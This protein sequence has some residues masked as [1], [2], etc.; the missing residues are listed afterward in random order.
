MFKLLPKN[1]LSDW[2]L[3][4]N[5]LSQSTLSDA[6]RKTQELWQSCPFTPF[7]LDPEKSQD[8]PDPWQLITEN[9]YC[10][11]ARCLG[12]I[13]TLHLTAH[14]DQLFPELRTYVDTNTRYDYHIAYLCHGKYVLNLIEGE[15]VNKEHINQQLKLKR[16]YTTADLKL[17]QY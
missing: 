11:L 16:C 7:Y 15:V 9:Y 17:E 2:K 8:W 1:R 13:Y 6:V 4:R 14:K 5:K 3:F 12:I 10:D